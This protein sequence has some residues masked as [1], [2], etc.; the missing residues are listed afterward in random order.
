MVLVTKM[1]H[2]PMDLLTT[3]IYLNVPKSHN[4]IS[5]Q[6]KW[7]LKTKFPFSKNSG[8]CYILY[9]PLEVLEYIYLYIWY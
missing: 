9:S 8:T 5:H 3:Q 6:T 4:S 2:P 7:I 1:V